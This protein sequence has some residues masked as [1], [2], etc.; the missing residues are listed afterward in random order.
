M[1][2][3]DDLP[4]NVLVTDSQ[5]RILEANRNACRLFEIKPPSALP[6]TAYLQHQSVARPDLTSHVETGQ[7][8]SFEDIVQTTS[9]REIRVSVR[10]GRPE[11]FPDIRF[12]IVT[13]LSEAQ[14][15][16][17]EMIDFLAELTTAQIQIK[18]YTKEIE[19]FQK[20]V[21]TMNQAVILSD[22]GGTITF[23]NAFADKLFGRTVRGSC[24]SDL[25]KLFSYPGSL[26]L[27]EKAVLA[28]NQAG[29][30]LVL[31]E[32]LGHET[33]CFLQLLPLKDQ[34]SV[35]GLVW[36]LFELT[37]EIANTQSFIDFSAELAT[38]NRD[39][40]NKN[41]EIL[42]LSQTD[43]LTGLHNRGHIMNL[44]ETILNHG[45]REEFAIL[46]FD[47]DN[48]KACNDQ[49]GH[50]FG[51]QVIKAVCAA[52]AE[53]LKDHGEL[54]RYG[55]EEF[56]ALLPGHGGSTAQTLGEAVRSAVEKLS[57]SFH[58]VLQGSKITV[59]IGATGRLESDTVDQM[60][61]RADTALYQGKRAGKN[62]VVLT[63]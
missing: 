39:L 5:G 12:W 34:E 57:G 58:D 14:E 25:V 55:G 16:R 33:R 18:K 54:G 31:N 36:I 37:E 15:D 9:G 52:A 26:N 4:D 45:R 61:M 13:D 28:S 48:F 50:Q 49:Y 2:F 20:I 24:T 38:M 21:D 43:A 23:S 62:R 19:I 3:L 42:R 17:Q 46:L 1:D 8:L 60:L 27:D 35:P 32:S 10:L 53:A 6:F 11:R 47:I 22:S 51:D 40:Q 59:T 7:S 56:L 29:E 30:V 44:F 63:S 41:R